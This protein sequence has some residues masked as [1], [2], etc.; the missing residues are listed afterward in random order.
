[1]CDKVAAGFIAQTREAT[2]WSEGYIIY[3]ILFS[4]AELRRG[5]MFG[6]VSSGTYIVI[7]ARVTT[8]TCAAF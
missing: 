2:I 5:V 4:A 3:F 7:S 8:F 6:Y 1:L